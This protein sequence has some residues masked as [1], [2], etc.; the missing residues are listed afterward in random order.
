ME[1]QILIQVSP[2][3]LT[4]L[5]TKGVNL[6]LSEAIKEFR[7]DEDDLMT[8]DQTSELL[9]VGK[10]TLW[11]WT[12]LHKIKA[13]GLGNRVFYKRSEIEKAL[14]PLNSHL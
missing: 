3:E 13:Y 6:N 11:R 1:Q 12:K 7:N 14:I 10:T 9:K 4:E 8:L 2:E 5:I